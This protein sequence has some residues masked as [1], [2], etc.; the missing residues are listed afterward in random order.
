MEYQTGF[1]VWLTGLPSAGKTTLAN[2]LARHLRDRGEGKVEVLAGSDTEQHLGSE[3]EEKETAVR[4]MAFVCDL[5]S[6]NGVIAVAASVSPD[7]ETREYARQ[8]IGRFVEI[9]VDCPP[10]VCVERYAEVPN[11]GAGGRI[12]PL[13]GVCRYEPPLN[14]DA[15]CKTSEEPPEDSVKKIVA[16]LER[17]QYL[18]PV[19]A[20]YSAQEEEQV[21][22]RLEGLGYL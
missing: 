4:R 6:R 8:M 2:L 18:P 15:V 17:L 10:E 22:K 20:A 1:T 14:P 13:G 3:E 21:R 16:A 5:L 7:R 12:G 11:P 9:F 19:A